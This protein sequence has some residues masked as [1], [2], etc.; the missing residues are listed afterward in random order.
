MP[1]QNR[2]DHLTL[3]AALRVFAEHHGSKR[4]RHITAAEKDML[5][6]AVTLLEKSAPYHLAFPSQEGDIP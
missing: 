3:A 5:L 1:S 4:I 6:R 2:Y